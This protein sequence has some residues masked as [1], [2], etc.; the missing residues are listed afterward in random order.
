[1]NTFSKTLVALSLAGVS[2]FAS[3][4]QI[5][6]NPILPADCSLLA[7]QVTLNLSTNVIGAYNCDVPNTRVDIGACHESGSRKPLVV[8]C[9]AVGVDPVS[10]DNI[11]NDDSCDGTPQQTFTIADYR[12]Y[13]ASTSG[14]S[15]GASDLGGNCNAGAAEGLVN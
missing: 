1:M 5:D 13:Q 4:V 6:G 9:T 10:G 7:E 8:N 2:S 3:A 14:G 15:V 11:Y 12:G